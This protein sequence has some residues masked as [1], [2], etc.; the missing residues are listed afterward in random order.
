M[1]AGTHTY[2]VDYKENRG[3]MNKISG[4]YQCQYPGYE[5]VLH[6]ILYSFPVITGGNWENM[7]GVYIISYN[8]M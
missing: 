3:N 8:C 7:K 4:W 5:I 6:V 1:H 2:T